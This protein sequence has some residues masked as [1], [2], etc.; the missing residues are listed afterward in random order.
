M[1]R[2]Q[3]PEMSEV[4]GVVFEADSGD[5]WLLVSCACCHRLFQPAT[6]HQAVCEECAR[7][8][9]EPSAR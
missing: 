3:A 6:E 2:G 5:E 1:N 8:A 7:E 9:I 4:I